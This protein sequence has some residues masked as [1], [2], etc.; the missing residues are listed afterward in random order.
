[1]KILSLSLKLDK[2]FVALSPSLYTGVANPDVREGQVEW[3]GQTS[4]FSKPGSETTLPPI[5]HAVGTMPPSIS[6]VAGLG[7]CTACGNI[8]LI[9]KARPKPIPVTRA[10]GKTGFSL[11]P[12]FLVNG[13][14]ASCCWHQF[15]LQSSI[16]FP[17]NTTANQGGWCPWHSENPH[18][19][20][21]VVLYYQGECQLQG[22]MQHYQGSD[23]IHQSEFRFPS[24]LFV[25]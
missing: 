3:S 9:F 15:T 5:W 16:C 7:A 13:T 12:L 6:A 14:M 19:A 23:V 20:R 8:S 4:R 11:S 1:M 24:P 18:P 2:I 10:S 22:C 21:S 25:R 17:P